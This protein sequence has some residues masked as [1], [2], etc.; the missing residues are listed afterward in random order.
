MTARTNIQS[1][2]IFISIQSSWDRAWIVRNVLAGN[3]QNGAILHSCATYVKIP[4][5]NKQA[6][7][8]E[9][10]FET[11]ISSNNDVLTFKYF[12]PQ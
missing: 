2:S 1:K 8:M 9:D 6:G 5:N 7:K 12:G 10:Q 4:I 3:Y 11:Q